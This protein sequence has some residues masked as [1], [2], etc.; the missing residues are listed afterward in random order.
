MIRIFTGHG[1][2]GTQYLGGSAFKL[3]D[4]NIALPIQSYW[5]FNS[6]DMSRLNAVALQMRKTPE[7]DEQFIELIRA[8]YLNRLRA[9]TKYTHSIAVDASAY[10]VFLLPYLLRDPDVKIV[11][12]IRSPLD[13]LSSVN[14]PPLNKSFMTCSALANARSLSVPDP[15]HGWIGAF[16]PP[17]D[18]EIGRNLEEYALPVRLCYFWL[19]VARCFT[20]VLDHP[21][22]Q[23]RLFKN[24]MNDE[25]YRGDA[26]DFLDLPEVQHLDRTVDRFQEHPKTVFN[27]SDVQPVLSLCKEAWRNL[28]AK[29]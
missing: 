11:G 14:R 3:Y 28:L 27:E 24:F 4:N 20:E 26:L 21:R 18:D 29:Y 8:R 10:T 17:T 12:L 25:E 16:A 22:F 9:T 2:T 13:Y 6:S 1:R 15:G 5:E 7:H 23:V 19:C